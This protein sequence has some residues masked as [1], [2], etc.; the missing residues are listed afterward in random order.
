MGY[1]VTDNW[2]RGRGRG[3][4]TD[5]EVGEN[6]IKGGG[7]VEEAILRTEKGE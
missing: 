6:E 4:G 2:E 5:T 3:R 1:L 7:R